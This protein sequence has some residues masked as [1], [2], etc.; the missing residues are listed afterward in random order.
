MHLIQGI[1]RESADTIKLSIGMTYH[2]T[3]SDALLSPGLWHASCTLTTKMLTGFP[4][5][6]PSLFGPLQ[7]AN[8]EGL[9]T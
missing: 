2:N 9:E 4:Q 8:R 5:V 3:P 1:F 7:H 6:Q